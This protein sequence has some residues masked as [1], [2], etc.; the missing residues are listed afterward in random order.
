L[1][2]FSIKLFRL[3]KKFLF[4]VVSIFTLYFLTLI[5][6]FFSAM[7]NLLKLAFIQNISSR[8]HLES[9]SQGS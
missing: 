4:S 5:S 9:T 2:D 1:V 7:R 3:S 6:R 8:S